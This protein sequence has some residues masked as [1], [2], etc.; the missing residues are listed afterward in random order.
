MCSKRLHLAVGI[1]GALLLA[2]T[3]SAR[4]QQDFFRSSPGDLSKSHEDIDGQANCNECH[5]GGKTTNDNK[6]LNCH[7]HKDLK[8]RI[9]ARQGFHASNKVSGKKCE[10][11]HLEHRGRKFDIRGWPSVAGG[12][13]GFDHRLTGWPLKDKHAAIECKDCHKSV[14]KQ[15]LRVYLGE[16]KFCG[17]CHKADQPHEFDRKAMMACDRCHSEAAWKPQLRKMQFNHNSSSDAAM[18]L[19]GSHEEVTCGKCHPKAQFNL[20]KKVPDDCANCH[21]DPHDGH[22]FGL[23]KCSW[24][25]SPTYRQLSTYKFDHKR[26]TRFDTTGAHQKIA[27]YDCHN[28]KLGTRKPSADC[29]AAGCHLKDNI[30][31]TRFNQFGSPLPKCG[32]CHPS[33]SWKAAVF[34]HDRRTK[35]R[36]TGKHAVTDCRGCHR[37]TLEPK[38]TFERFDPKT[39][40]CMGCHEHKNVHDGEFKDKECTRCHK[41]AGEIAITQKAVDLYHGPKSRFPLVKAHKGVKCDQCHTNNVYE[42]TPRECGVRCH[43]DSLHRGTL[44]DLCSNC[45]SGGEWAAVRFNHDED[46]KW[47]LK[48]WHKRIPKCEDCHARREDYHKTPTNCSAEGC[49]A[50]DD[51]HRGRLGNDCEIC[52][53]E[54]GKNIFD[55]NKH[56]DYKLDGAHLTTQCAECHPSITFKPRPTNCFGCHPEPDVHKGQFGTR[57]E[58][59]HNT[60]SFDQFLPLHDVGSFSLRGAHDNLDCKACH[61]DSR[62]LAGTGNLCITCHRQDDIHYNSLSPQCGDCHTQWTFAPARFDHT[63]VGCN[64]TGLHK[65]LPCYDCH[66]TGNFG[67]LSPT[68]YGCHAADARRVV[69]AGAAIDHAGFIDCGNCH[70]PNSFRPAQGAFA[71][72]RESICR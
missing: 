67:G 45:H 33:T 39:V 65:A 35:F 23:K 5:D 25:H 10:R 29:E 52:H 69:V 22:L 34:N 18:P 68:C 62:P 49:H 56:S 16:D 38:F 54:T 14:N 1:A 57:C 8:Q 55:H 44:G 60:V 37:G 50:K 28:A 7:D 30:H 66:Q 24:C 2:S 17:G 19:E 58:S 63:Q 21:E 46:T 3:G 15:G 53:L 13:K 9:D 40:G 47:P 70:N 59:C 20:K 6:C 31:G 32:T 36:L 64:L 48:G 41:S 72:G 42:N 12:E 26:R 51:V 43:E 61:K 4:A 11:C 27:C 71:Y